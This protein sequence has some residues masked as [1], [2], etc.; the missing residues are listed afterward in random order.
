MLVGRKVSEYS[1][2]PWESVS[3]FP[4]NVTGFGVH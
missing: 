3:S 4:L 1:D 2:G